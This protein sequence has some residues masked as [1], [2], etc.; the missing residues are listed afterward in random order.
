LL[1]N[2]PLKEVPADLEEKVKSLL[3]ECWGEFRGSGET[4]MDAYKVGRAEKLRWNPP[5][6]SFIV[7]RH[8]RTA[9]GSTRAE[10]QEWSL[11]FEKME[12]IWEIKS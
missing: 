9:M 3:I 2:L 12:A 10:L 1:Q 7:E 4:Q 6:L 5:V 8:S 11:D